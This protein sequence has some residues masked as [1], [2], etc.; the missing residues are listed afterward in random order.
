MFWQDKKIFKKLREERETT[1][2]KAFA[3]AKA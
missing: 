1:Y 2:D 3:S